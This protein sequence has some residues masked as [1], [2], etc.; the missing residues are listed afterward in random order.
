MRRS[1]RIT[2]GAIGWAVAIAVAWVASLT[3]IAIGAS[4]AWRWL[5]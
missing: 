1:T 3:L 5:T 4:L 2:L